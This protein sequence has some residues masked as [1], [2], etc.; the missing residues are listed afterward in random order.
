M[1]GSPPGA[2]R[3]SSAIRQLMLTCLSE[4][5]RVYRVGAAKGEK[6]I[7]GTVGRADIW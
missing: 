1:Y 3:D 4:L 5:R 2:T 6:A 7:H